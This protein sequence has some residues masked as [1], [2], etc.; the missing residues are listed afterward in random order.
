MPRPC[1]EFSGTYAQPA[2]MP[3]GAPCLPPPVRSA[4]SRTLDHEPHL[5]QLP[6]RATGPGTTHTAPWIGCQQGS[7]STNVRSPLAGLRLRQVFRTV[8]SAPHMS[9]RTSRLAL[10]SAGGAVEIV[11]RGG[12]PDAVLLSTIRVPD[13]AAGGTLK[14]SLLDRPATVQVHILRPD[15]TDHRACASLRKCSRP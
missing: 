9:Q 13:V 10:D 14:L 8:A 4:S 12:E 1:A 6:K 11:L 3:D 15:H 7:H 5:V 2:Q